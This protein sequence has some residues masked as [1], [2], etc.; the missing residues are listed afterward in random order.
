MLLNLTRIYVFDNQILHI[1]EG[2]ISRYS[3]NFNLIEVISNRSGYGVELPFLLPNG[4]QTQGVLLFSRGSFTVP[5]DVDSSLNNYV[6]ESW[7]RYSNVIPT[8]ILSAV[9]SLNSEAVRFIIKFTKTEEGIIVQRFQTEVGTLALQ[10]SFAGEIVEIEA[11]AAVQLLQFVNELVDNINLIV[12]ELFN[13]V[14]SGEE[15]QE[16]IILE[17]TPKFLLKSGDTMTGVLNMLANIDM[18]NNT[19]ENINGLNA[20][21]AE[22]SDLLVTNNATVEGDLNV[23]GDLIVDN[24]NVK[25]TLTSLEEDKLARDGSQEML[26]DLN[27]GNN[28]IN[29][30]DTLNADN[31]VSDE[32]NTNEVKTQLIT[33][34]LEVIINAVQDIELQR[35][36]LDKLHIR[37]DRIKFFEK[38]KFDIK[39]D[40]ENVKEINGVD[41][42]ALVDTV[43]SLIGSFVFR[44]VVAKD[45][46][47][48]TADKT[49]LTAFVTSELQRSPQLGD[50]VK[51]SDGGEWYYDG[52]DWRYVG[53]TFVDL[54][55][56]ALIANV[57]LLDGS[58]AMEDDLN[59][60][61]NKGV[62]LAPP[63]ANNDATNKTYVDQ[64]LIALENATNI[65]LETKAEISF[66]EQRIKDLA[67]KFGLEDS[68]VEKTE[69]VFEFNNGDDIP[70][71]K[72]EDFVFVLT[73]FKRDDSVITNSTFQPS[74]VEQNDLSRA[75]IKR[76]P[77][78]WAQLMK[79]N[80]NIEFRIKDDQNTTQTDTPTTLRMTGFRLKEVMRLGVD[81]QD[82]NRIDFL[83][84]A[85][86]D[87]KLAYEI[88]EGE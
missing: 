58:Q 18:N 4:V 36:G 15:G 81:N 47:T 40:I 38:I 32:V 77:P 61:N 44:G 71:E 19:I 54:S 67:L 66:V 70:F 33:S 76:T 1:Q 84:L 75:L 23:E 51:D 11:D 60:G 12:D 73:R 74:L 39:R 78:R 6:G 42:D 27:V 10:G 31:V 86:I 8:S 25:Q 85:I 41:F 16:H 59:F 80:G 87:N 52:S 43:N 62:N 72:V 65:L 79:N 34:A 13:V 29:N 64:A 50:V 53:Q 88:E 2:E 63:T 28:N 48:V 26:G 55:P 46:E 30:V 83:K 17:L 69:G 22:L 21:F 9:A 37:E 35:S 49:I 68:A 3:G 82:A 7:T 14:Y 5:D 45:T 24:T 20:T 57:L 56:Y